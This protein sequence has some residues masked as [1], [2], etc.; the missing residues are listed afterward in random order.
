[1][2][3]RDNDMKK[4]M[5]EF[6]TALSDNNFE[7]LEEIIED[8]YTQFSQLYWL[9]KAYSDYITSLSYKVTK[10]EKLKVEMTVTKLNIN[11]VLEEMQKNIPDNSDILIWNN[12]R[13]IHIE[14]TKDEDSVA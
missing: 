3:E 10:K 2:K 1:M 4:S 6:I 7:V 13:I 8:K 14:I 12:K 9:I 5:P 11:K